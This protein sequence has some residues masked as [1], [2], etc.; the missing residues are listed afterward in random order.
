[1]NMLA[2][3]FRNHCLFT[4]I[5][6]TDPFQVPVNILN[7]GIMRIEKKKIPPF[8]KSY[9]TIII[10]VNMLNKSCEFIIVNFNPCKK[11]LPQLLREDD[12]QKKETIPNEMQ[13]LRVITSI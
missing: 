3:A 12:S 10:L 1:M 11:K 6:K 4:N 2:D 13:I 5:Y 8:F 7:G 9:N